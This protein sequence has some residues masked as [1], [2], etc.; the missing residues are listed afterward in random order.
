MSEEMVPGWTPHE[1]GYLPASLSF[2]AL[3]HGFVTL[4]SV[5]AAISAARGRAM[6]APTSGLEA[7]SGKGHPSGRFAASSHQGELNV[8]RAASFKGARDT[9]LCSMVRKERTQIDVPFGLR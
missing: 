9:N 1:M 3:E 2:S 4:N 6:R 5:G 7:D 8:Y